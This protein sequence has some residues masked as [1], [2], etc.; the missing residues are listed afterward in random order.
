MFYE[1]QIQIYYR[2]LPITKLF[3]NYSLLTGLKLWPKIGQFIAI[4]VVNVLYQKEKPLQTFDL[5]GLNDAL[6]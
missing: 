6:L 1:E 5:Q 3:N 4:F 2:W